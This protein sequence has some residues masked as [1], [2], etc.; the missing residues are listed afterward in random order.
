MR[1]PLSWL[2]S[3][4]DLPDDLTPRALGDV[5]L[6]AGLEV[7]TV[8]T[9]DVDGPLVV[10]AVLAFEVETHKNGKSIRWCQVDVGEDDPRGIVCGAHNFAVGDR[11]VVALP[12]AVLPGG[13]EIA[14]RRTYGHISDG[15][16]C[17]VRELG[18]GD[19]H[20]GILVL[21]DDDLVGLRGAASTHDVTPGAQARP[22]LGLPDAVLDI[23]VTPD[24]GYCLSVRGVAR[25]AATALAS[26]FR[27][28]AE[29]ARL[30]PGAP[31]PTERAAWPV[32]ID[33]A[34]G[35]DRFAVRVA[36][37]LDPT[38]RSP[39]WLRTR[40]HLA[41]MRPISLAVDVTNHVMLEVGQPIHGYDADR[42]TGG[43]GVRRAD[44]GESLQTLDGK[45]R[46][47]DPEDLVITDGSGAIGVAGVMGGATT[48]LSEQT[49]HV[50]VEAAH[51]DPVTISRSAR[52][53]KLPS[54]ASRRFERGVDPALPPVAAGL[55]VQ[56]L[57]DLGGA[58]I[59]PALTD[60]DLRVPG[61][62]IPLPVDDP[63]RIAGRPDEPGVDGMLAVTAPS[64]RPDLT[65]PVDLVEEVVRLA[66]YD[67]IPA[68]VPTGPSSHGLTRAQQQ[69]QVI[70]RAIAHAGGIQ[71][72]TYP[73][74]G[75]GMLDAMGVPL[76]AP[77]RL[78][79]RLAN[80]I[81]DEE[82]YLR[83]A[84][85]PGLLQALRRNVGR[86]LSDLTLFE[87]G[88]VF[89]PRPGQV[90]STP[91]L[92][93]ERRPDDDELARLD[94]GLPHQ[95]RRLAVVVAGKSERD[96]WYGP[97][98]ESQWLDAIA[99]ARLAARMIDAPLTVRATE[100]MPWHPGR[101]A[102]LLV[103]DERIGY[104]GELHPR[105]CAA[106]DLPPRVGA[107]EIDVERL[108]AYAE[109]IVPAPRVSTFPP[110]REDL[111]F[112][113]D[114]TVPAGDL[115]E[116]LTEAG[117]ELLE[118][119]WLFDVYTGP[120]VGEGRKSLAYNVTLRAADHTLTVEELSRARAAMVDAAAQRLGAELRSG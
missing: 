87:L 50:V 3:Y 105:V 13:F 22:V 32:T 52:R 71:V 79:V 36:R 92:S 49:R 118:Q 97:G 106:L 93:V 81:S 89:L 96:A 16:I 101:C 82:P 33:D 54:E 111:A 60:V 47:L 94:A 95:P 114:E 61:S 80:P 77:E 18:I 17:S 84:L 73:F 1:V 75:D 85:L 2:R 117:G 34:G 108:A 21:A 72:A 6:S 90:I 110:A 12:G 14:A 83:A 11:V 70:T 68:T 38:R 62:T 4:V 35:C 9:V 113:V 39:L 63:G 27:D 120:Q 67:T 107:M 24:R 46:A 65:D 55:V 8:E 48:E 28:P 40:L 37:D 115:A 109:P 116:V 42:L 29:P 103:V 119:L 104:A 112:V 86:G 51:F 20:D 56:M 64:W 53:H 41:G 5:L 31:V 58:T 74:V 57:A 19:E 76:D 78:R 26:V 102:E 10:G 59:A 30:G 91:R 44:A 66:G 23:A 88:R 99:A 25:E 43:L 7:E 45:A 98:R 69:E 100:R 15:M